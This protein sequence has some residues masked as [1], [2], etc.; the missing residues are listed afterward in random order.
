MLRKSLS[1]P[2]ALVPAYLLFLLIPAGQL[3]ADEPPTAQLEVSVS[4]QLKGAPVNTAKLQAVHGVAK[5]F[6]KGAVDPVPFS[7][8]FSQPATLKLPPGR[9]VLQAESPGAWSKGYQLELTDQ[10][11]L[12]AL[13]L[14]PAGTIEGGLTLQD[15]V[16]APA[17]LVASFRPV[18]EVPASQAPPRSQV[19][20]PVEKEKQTWRC[21][22]PAGSLDLRIQ[23]PGFIPRY[24]WGARIEAGG[25][26]RPG[27][28]DLRRGSAVL[29]WIV[30]ANGT[31]LGNGAEVSLRP[32]GGQGVRGEGQRQRLEELNFKAAVNPRGFFQMDGVPPGA[33]I[34]E[35]R[36]ERFAPATTSVKVVPGEV[37]EVANPPLILE[38]PKVL[39]VY[40]DPATDP[41]GQPWTAKLQKL[42]RDSSVLTPVAEGAIAL[43]GSWRKP[44]IPP[45][46]YLLRIGL[47]S[48][49]T[50]WLDQ[51][52]LTENPAPVQV[53]LDFVDVKGSVHLGKKPLPAKLWFGGQF[54]AVRMEA[55][56]DEKGKF[57]ALLPKSGEWVVHV[58][59]EDPPVQ[60]EIPKVKIEPKPGTHVAELDLRLP[61]TI[62][63][64][65]VVDEKG[66]PIGK[67]IVTALSN[68]AVR[69]DGVQARTD[70]AGH[71]EFRGLLP[72]TTLV[73]ADAGQDRFA[74][75]V[76]VDVPEEKDSPSIVLIARPQLRLSGTVVSSAG[77]V[78]GARIKAAPAGMPYIGVHTVTSDV[79]GHFEVVLPPKAQEMLLSVG[80][81]GFAFRMLRVPVPEN[82]QFT[83]GV[84][85]AAGTLVIERDDTLDA[86]IRTRP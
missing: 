51:I 7:A 3:V 19:V 36:H 42:D 11:A 2:K 82:R 63:R 56:A 50:W 58:E 78:A 81:P 67:A 22:V 49:E 23:S 9:W 64:G 72:G 29:G 8:S 76:A 53:R 34:L 26:L 75:P 38:L 20:Y 45:G 13:E 69:E 10:G 40:V 4:V 59:S 30:T 27:R 16:A 44:G 15:G 25:T 12:V 54:G 24:L 47:K 1:S 14:W 52:E 84:D 60:R 70:E 35:A 83:V 66:E 43:D 57:K 31:P 65:R 28:L 68:G 74:H 6:G 85:Q 46:R 71:F 18:P 37:T 62:L 41:S 33:Y 39:E 21:V 17:E 73:E 77:P 5:W 32:R 55:Q 80:A 86:W 61:D 79:Q 48:G